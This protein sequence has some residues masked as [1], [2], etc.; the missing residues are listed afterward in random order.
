MSMREFVTQNI[1]SI[2]TH[3]Y[4]HIDKYTNVTFYNSNNNVSSRDNDLQAA[5]EVHLPCLSPT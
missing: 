2:H 5:M 4:I 3:A 1:P